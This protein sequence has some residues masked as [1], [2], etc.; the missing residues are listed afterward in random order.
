[1]K[2]YLFRTV[3]LSI[4]MSY[5][6]HIQQWYMSYMFLKFILEIKLYMFRTVTLSIL[7]SRIRMEL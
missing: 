6:L 3:T 1:M 7:R 2:L 4:L 5:S